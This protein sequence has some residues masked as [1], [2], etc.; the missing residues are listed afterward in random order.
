MIFIRQNS[1]R[2]CDPT[3]SFKK[4]CRTNLKVR[5]PAYDTKARMGFWLGNTPEY[6]TLYETDGDEWIIPY[7]TTTL[8]PWE[9]LQEA[10]VFDAYHK[11]SEVDFKAD[12]PLYDYQQEA[13]SVMVEQG[14]GILQAPAGSGKTQMGLSIA[15]KIGKKTLWLCHTKDLLNQSKQR[16]K[17]YMDSDLIGTIAEGKVNIGKGITFATVQTMSKLNLNKYRN[18]WDCIITDEVHRVSGSPTAV[19]QYQKVLD[20]LDA[21]HKYGLSATVHRSDG[22]IIATKALVGDVMYNVSQDDVADTVLTVGIKPVETGTQISRE[23][24]NSDGTLNY[25]RLI[26]YLAENEDRTQL[27]V[28]NIEEGRPSIILSDRLAH[29]ES[30]VSALPDTMKKDAVIISGRMTSKKGKAEREQALEDMRSGKKKYLFATYALCKEGLDIPR[31][32][33]LYMASPVKDYAV[34]TQAIGRIARKFDGKDDP[35]CYDFVDD[36]GYLVRS[37]KQRC[38][39]YKK[40]RCYFV[41]IGG[42]E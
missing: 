26:S 17:L 22:L 9:I 23:C 6:L 10:L 20:S 1:I 29:L 28:N 37:Y 35:I 14:M 8:L 42:A 18:T 39:T 31:L 24:L 21:P 15:T 30:M 7:G 2:V 3:E 19:T 25:Q 16:A 27:I 38:S 11:S 34:V 33:R 41:E 13:V 5:N 12:I 36:I 40:N 4:W 32:E